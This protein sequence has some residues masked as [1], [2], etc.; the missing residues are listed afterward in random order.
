[1]LR[2]WCST[3]LSTTFQL[4]RVGQFLLV[5]EIGV[6]G[7]NLRPVVSHNILS[8]SFRLDFGTVLTMW[9]VQ[10]VVFISIEVYVE[11]R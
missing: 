8:G 7:E 4:Y 5:E 10:F 6:L 11:F 9:Y 2:L 1:V 3:P